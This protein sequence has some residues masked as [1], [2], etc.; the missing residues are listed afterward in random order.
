MPLLTLIEEGRV[1]IGIW[2]AC[3]DLPELASRLPEHSSEAAVAQR[4]F[5]SDRRRKEWL[6]ARVLLG[7]MAGPGARI[8]Y[9][10]SGKPYL[11]NDSRPI[12]ISHTAQWAA[13]AISEAENVGLD[14]EQW[15]HRALRVKDKF[16]SPA[17]EE[18]MRCGSPAQRAVEA[19]SGKECV[20]KLF[21]HDQLA[22]KDDIFLHDFSASGTSA[23]CRAKV[24]GR[25]AD[26]QLH[27][28]HFPHFV[29]TWALEQALPSSKGNKLAPL[30][31]KRNT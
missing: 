2:E 28:R 15:G 26:L 17:E 11:K 20:F 30:F 22:L 4:L 6:A 8:A 23:T 7:R 1:R 16:L 24:A 3:E 19:W 14:I 29:L 21:G 5:S 31:P 27:I 10:P 12:S 13:L 25:T 9:A 18:I